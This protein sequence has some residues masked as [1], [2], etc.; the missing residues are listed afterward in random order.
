MKDGSK[1]IADKNNISPTLMVGRKAIIPTMFPEACW[2][3]IAT[4]VKFNDE[5]IIR[6]LS[7]TL[8]QP[9]TDAK[10]IMLTMTNSS[11]LQITFLNDNNDTDIS[12]FEFSKCGDLKGLF[13][14][15]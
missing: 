13:K 9:R 14:D 4:E 8:N 1:T 6:I 15:F 5:K 3:I 12:E 11:L 10:Y 7:H 2:E